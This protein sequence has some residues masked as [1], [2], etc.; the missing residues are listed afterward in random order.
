MH[1]D[2]KEKKTKVNRTKDKDKKN[3][4]KEREAGQKT[5]TNDAHHAGRD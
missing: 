4:K 1:A 2:T 5:E 3:T